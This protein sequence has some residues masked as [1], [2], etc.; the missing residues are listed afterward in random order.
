MTSATTRGQRDIGSFFEA[1][2]ADL[3]GPVAPPPWETSRPPISYVQT[4][5]QALAALAATYS[6]EGR[7]R[8]IAPRYL[9]DSMLSGFIPSQWNLEVFSVMHDLTP[10]VSDLLKKVQ[11]PAKSVILSATYF[12]AEPS[13]EYVDATE[14]LRRRGA[15]V[16]EDETHRVL[17]S[18]APIGDVAIA[19]LRKL[20]PVADGAYVRGDASVSPRV[21]RTHSGW[22]A[23][24]EKMRDGETARGL[25][26]KANE[27]LESVTRPPAYASERTLSTVA[28]LDYGA[29]RARRRANATCLHGLLSDVDRVEVVSHAD[30]PSHF[31]V[32]VPD[33]KRVQSYLATVRVF[34]PIHWPRPERLDA[35]QWPRGLLSLPVDHRYD[36]SDMERVAAQLKMAVTL[37]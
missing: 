21:S 15:R 8:L 34:C 11:R 1:V 12:G 23:M 6:G 24:D 33:A 32:R 30:V 25:F 4:A 36:D 3:L 37:C 10:E 20:L 29:I 27:M 17:G 5:R 16:I 22:S 14:T 28:R 31:V 9:C 19:S 7:T 2:N 26:D 35:I 13:D 18:L